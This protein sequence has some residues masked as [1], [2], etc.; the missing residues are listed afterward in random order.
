MKKSTLLV[1]IFLA[2]MTSKGQDTLPLLFNYMDDIVDEG[3]DFG[4][5]TAIWR[6]GTL[7]L[8]N[9]TVDYQSGRRGFSLIFYDTLGS[10]TWDKVYSDPRYLNIQGNDILTFDSNYFFV[11]GVF[12][13][14]TMT[15]WDSFLAKFDQNGDTVYF[16][17]YIDTASLWLVDIEKYAPDTLLFLSVWQEIMN[18]S[19]TK[20]VLSK[21]DTSGNLL[22]TSRDSLKQMS[23]YEMLIHNDQIYVGGTKRTNPSSNFNVKVFINRYDL[24]FNYLGS[25][26]PSLTPNEYFRSFTV[27]DENLLLTSCVSLWFPPDLYTHWRINI[28]RL[29][30]NGLLIDTNTFGPHSPCCE[31]GAKT[32]NLNDEFLLTYINAN[33]VELYFHDPYLNPLCNYILQRPAEG[34]AIAYLWDI[35]YFPPNKFTGNGYTF[36]DVNGGIENQWDFLSDDVISYINSNCIYMMNEEIGPVQNMF[37]ISPNIITSQAV[38]NN[39]SSILNCKILVK[40]FD[41][42]GRLVL[43]DEFY[44]EKTINV[45]SLMKGLYILQLNYNNQTEIHKII[46]N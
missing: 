39:Q 41:I 16:H 36:S 8:G 5:K 17:K 9:V 27:M 44:H 31:W 38:I 20:I 32:I 2:F 22:F 29:T 25:T 10:K 24:S 46:V 6:G 34:L 13:D 3:L 43:T 1:P 45:E 37:Q 18:D 4:N 15:P 23:P 11:G 30:E 12:Y 26:T 42:N 40:I 14:A 21:V 7:H 28:S 19:Y 35:Q 33:S